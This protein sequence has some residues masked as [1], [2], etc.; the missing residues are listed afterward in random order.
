[1]SFN[2]NIEQKELEE[3]TPLLVPKLKLTL[4]LPKPFQGIVE[5]EQSSTESDGDGENSCSDRENEH[6]NQQQSI[7][8][9]TTDE[10]DI[11][12]HIS[13]QYPFE[14]PNVNDNRNES[15]LKDTSIESNDT[16]QS[17][18]ESSSVADQSLKENADFNDTQQQEQEQIIH[19]TQINEQTIPPQALIPPAETQ[20]TDQFCG[21]TDNLNNILNN[22]NIITPPNSAEMV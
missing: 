8:Q 16:F 2:Q 9:I 5:S 17:N 3:T 12:M 20:F 18:D 21:S 13:H 15:S 4:K 6:E 10:K 14:A 22:E 7:H 1:M 11:S 19:E